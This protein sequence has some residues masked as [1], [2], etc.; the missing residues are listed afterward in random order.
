MIK[1]FI[2]ISLKKGWWTAI[3][4]LVTQCS[5][6]HNFNVSVAG[7]HPVANCIS[8]SVQYDAFDIH[9]DEL[10]QFHSETNRTPNLVHNTQGPWQEIHPDDCSEE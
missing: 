1:T 10:P 6:L 4:L 7:C 5:E 3:E 2:L 8:F 9:L